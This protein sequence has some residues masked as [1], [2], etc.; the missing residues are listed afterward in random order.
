MTEVRAEE[1]RPS[2]ALQRLG[3]LLGVTWF[4]FLTFSDPDRPLWLRVGYAVTA[5][6]FAAGTTAELVTAGRRR[7][8]AT[9]SD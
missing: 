7:F 2:R 6:V 3:G 9:E 1:R 4:T 8:R 5:L